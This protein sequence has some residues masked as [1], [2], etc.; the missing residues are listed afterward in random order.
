MNVLL[1]IILG[2]VGVGLL[3]LELFLLPGFGI[4][5]IGGFVSLAAAVV[6]AYTTISHLAG[7]ITLVT[8]MVLSIIAIILFFR[9]HAIEKM[10]L[11]T[12]IDSQVGLA[13]PGKNMEE[14][15]GQNI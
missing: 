7:T 10:A 13:D 6:L 12:T 15:S 1:V 4:A 14:K 11:D 8:A 3:L 2:V 9:G 5:G